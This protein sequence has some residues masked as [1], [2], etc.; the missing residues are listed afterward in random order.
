MTI[1]R[2]LKIIA[3]LLGLVALALAVPEAFVFLMSLL[4][5]LATC[6]ALIVYWLAA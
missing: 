3:I 2:T 6:F 5:T 4:G 1:A